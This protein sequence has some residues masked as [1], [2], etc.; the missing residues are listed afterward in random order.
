MRRW[1]LL[2]CVCLSGW[3]VGCLTACTDE[4]EVMRSGRVVG[5]DVWAVVPFGCAGGGEVTVTTRASLGV[6]PE[7]RVHNLFVYVFVAGRRV[8]GH[9]FD[10]ESLLADEGLVR[11]SDSNCWF[12]QN[13]A[14]EA[15]AVGNPTRGV[16]RIKAPQCVGATLYLV[17]NV[18]ADMISVSPE[19]LYTVVTEEE[20]LGITAAMNQ[21]TMSRNGLFPMVAKVENV[22]L[23]ADGNLTTAGG[24]VTAWL[25][26]LDAKVKVRVRVAKGYK[27]QNDPDDVL[28]GGGTQRLESFEPESWQVMNVPRGCRLVEQVTDSEEAGYFHSAALTFEERETEDFTYVDA[29][30]QEQLVTDG[31]VN[32]F[33]FYMMENRETQRRKADVGGDYHLRDSRLKKADGTYDTLAGLWRYAPEQGTYLVIKGKIRMDV[34]ISS[35]AKAQ[36]LEADVVYYVHLG[37]F[38]TDRDNYDICRNTSYTYTITIKGVNRIELEVRTS[39]GGDPANVQEKESGATGEVYLAKE[40]IYTFDA[41]YGQ[42]VFCFDAAYI[43]PNNVT[44]YVRTPFGREGVPD[45][46]GDTE[47]PSGFDYKWVHF[48]VNPVDEET[49]TYSTKNQWYPGD[50]SP[51]LM[52]VVGFVSYIKE[53]ARL[54]QAGRANDF[55]EEEDPVWKAKFPDSPNLYRRKRIYATVY[56]DEFY[57]EKHPLSG[58]SDPDLWKKFVNQPDRLMHLLCDNYK[59]LDQASSATGSVIT[60]RQHAI[61]TPYTL[62]KDGLHT[63]WGCESMDETEEKHFWFYNTSETADIGPGTQPDLKNTSVENGLYNT[64]CLWGVVTDGTNYESVRWDCF[65]DYERENDYDDPYGGGTYFLRG[66]YSVMRYSALMRNRDNNGNGRIDPEEIRWYTASIDQLYGMYMGG[67]G[68]SAKSQLY[69]REWASQT[70]TYAS[71]P[72]AGFDRWRRHVVSSTQSDTG[73]DYAYY[74]VML[75]AEEGISVSAYSLDKAYDKRAALASV[76]VRNLG[77][78]HGRAEAEQSTADVLNLGYYPDLLIGVERPLDESDPA[79]VYRFDLSNINTHSLRFFTSHELEPTDEFSEM[80]RLSSGFETGPMVDLGYTYLVGLRSTL[81]AGQS[82][83][84]TGYRVPN[85]REGALMYLFCK[86]AGWWNDQW[87]LVGTS[88]FN[89]GK[90]TSNQGSWQMNHANAT[91]GRQGVTT[92]RCVRDVP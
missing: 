62:L 8:Y 7:S 22:T 81:L 6:E 59:S 38:A 20:L 71:G 61:Q 86:T 82:P 29:A 89:S 63:A 25:Q 79:G 41:H 51:R 11:K 45:K 1:I 91:I 57:Y 50:N 78:V 56:V 14:D 24:N 72:Y 44:W 9:Y 34:D 43:D 92:V 13:M 36:V 83:C 40:C 52:D 35:E 76:C 23:P 3:L 84:P 54:L 67:E 47:I 28:A 65:L 33:S 80:A 48:L 85:V 69:N 15:D 70:G 90:D 27:A 39:E 12:V 58:E 87:T 77:Y 10:S 66:P 32:I 4:V 73:G 21:I 18:D 2:F 37:D 88:Y 46:V 16:I 75:W 5:D 31:E 55:R 74:P 19:K 60:I 53:Q 17:A 49:Q 26:R 68:L 42:R 64:A 30:G